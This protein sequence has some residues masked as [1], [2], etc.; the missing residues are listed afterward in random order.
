VAAV[1]A[2]LKTFWRWA[3]S[4]GMCAD[5]TAGLRR[6]K[7]EQKLIPALTVQQ[8]KSLLALCSKSS[9]VDRRN[10]ALLRLLLDTGLRI[11]EALGLTV[12]RLHLENGRAHVSGKGQ[13][14]RFV[15]IGPKTQRALLRYLAV[16][17]N[18]AFGTDAV[19]VNRDGSPMNRRHAHQMI[20]RLARRVGIEGV[21]VSPHTMRHSCALLF[22]RRGGD[23]LMLQRSLGHSRQRQD[24]VGSSALCVTVAASA[25]FP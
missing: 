21:R 5:I 17:R 14:E 1:T 3:A 4:Q 12:D 20:V 7:Q 23:A 13:K 18:A 15:F 11:S 10:D 6:P 22:L 19:F 2:R 24:T 25:G 9:F 8:L 16:R